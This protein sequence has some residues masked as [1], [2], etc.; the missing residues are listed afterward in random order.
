MFATKNLVIIQLCLLL[1]L[2]ISISHCSLSTSQK[3]G[4][5]GDNVA[6]C[7]N[8]CTI[9]CQFPCQPPPRPPTPSPPPPPPPPPRSYL[10]ETPPPP[11]SSGS[12]GVNCPPGSVPCCEY[13]NSPPMSGGGPFDQ[14]SQGQYVPP[15]PYT[16]VP[17]NNF[18]ASTT[19]RS[20]SDL[21][22]KPL[23]SA[24]FFMFFFSLT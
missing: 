14:G 20:T 17:Y 22:G 19:T 21:F 4:V 3:K 1:L 24:I 16:Y 10:T 11:A 7:T 2:Q 23:F 18:S 5:D 9:I 12:Q 13:P 6:A 15:S 8:N